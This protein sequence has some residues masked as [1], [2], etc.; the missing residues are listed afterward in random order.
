[1]PSNPY[2]N[3]DLSRQEIA[4]K[5]GRLI[6]LHGADGQRPDSFGRV[7][8]IFEYLDHVEVEVIELPK[9]AR[10]GDGDCPKSCSPCGSLSA[11]K[12]SNSRTFR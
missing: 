2:K 9:E 11:V 12:V 5:F 3:G 8:W 1:V 10:A 7:G 6:L 4:A